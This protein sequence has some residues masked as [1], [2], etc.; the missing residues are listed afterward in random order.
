MKKFFKKITDFI[1]AIIP[2]IFT[3]AGFCLLGYGL[4]LVKP[5]IAY[6]VCG[7]LL[8]VGGLLAGREEPREN[9]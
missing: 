6:S 9:V 7:I 5:W 4:W 2:L 3:V 1:S 8:L